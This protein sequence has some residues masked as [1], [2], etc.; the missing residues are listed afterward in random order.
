ML[1]TMAEQFIAN[2]ADVAEG[3]VITFVYRQDGIRRDGFL[4]LTK[5]GLRCYENQCR[6]LPVKLDSGSGHFLS[7]E[8]KLILCQSHGALYEPETGLCTRGPCQGASL[9]A[10]PVE[11]RDGKVY[12]TV[13]D[14]V[15]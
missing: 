7:R 9:K 12:L 3:K 4:L 5:V 13:V 6:H 14:E 10:L 8:K 11:V 2:A 1:A 15:R